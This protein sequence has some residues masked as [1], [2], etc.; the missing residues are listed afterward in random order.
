VR[1]AVDLMAKLDACLSRDREGNPVRVVNCFSGLPAA[2]V[3]PAAGEQ[4][5]ASAK[6]PGGGKRA[7]AAA[8]AGG[9]EQE[10]GVPG[11]HVCPWPDEHYDAFQRQ[12]GFAGEVWREL[13]AEA[14]DAGVALAFEMHPNFLVHNPETY[15]QLLEL[16]GDDGSVLGLN[17]D[18][19]HL[20]WRNMDPV[21]V[22]RYLN[23]T[24]GTAPIKHCH[25]KDTFVDRYNT[26]VNGNHSA[27]PYTREEDRV[28][29]FVTIG[30]GW[31]PVNGA[32]DLNWWARFITELQLGGYD[33]VMSIEH[34]D[35]RKSFAEGLGKALW[36][37]ER[38]VNREAPGPV[39]WAGR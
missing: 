36:V 29:R 11:W 28:W 9:A 25:G 8:W 3:R 30:E 4:E 35:S 14:R 1:D 21:A 37:L 12:M 27:L 20:F 13:A 26:A 31:D 16:A 15:L 2:D 18:P 7:E 33:H 39:T 19:S 38:V 23:R 22:V 34:E 17:F 5:D 6:G 10:G 24:L 32:H